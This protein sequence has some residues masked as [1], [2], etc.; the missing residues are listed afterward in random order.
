ML[1][2]DSSGNSL[3]YTMTGNPG[4]SGGLAADIQARVGDV[5]GYFVHDNVTQQGSNAQFRIIDL[6][7]GRLFE[8][9]LTGNPANKR[10][11]LQPEAYSGPGIQT[12]P[13]SNRTGRGNFTL[14][15]TR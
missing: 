5:V 4:I 14:R 2:V 12:D 13:V 15:L 8:V 10:I 7:F 11:V 1:F 6:R 3:N 9:D